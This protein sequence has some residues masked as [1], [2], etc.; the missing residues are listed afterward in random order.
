M[1]SLKY[2]L[3]CLIV[4][5][6]AL[7]VGG[8][9]EPMLT[10]RRKVV[11]PA[12][13][14]L[15]QDLATRFPILVL[16]GFRGPLVMALW[17]QA[18]EL[19]NQRKWHEVT[20]LHNLIA[21]LQ[22]HFGS[23]YVFNAW[24][25]AYNMSAQWQSLEK[26]YEWV[27]KGLDYA[28]L[29]LRYV[30][31]NPDLVHQLQFIYDHKLGRSHEK[32]F[33]RRRFREDSL[34]FPV[35]DREKYPDAALPFDY[36]PDGPVP[37]DYQEITDPETFPFGQSPFY[38]SFKYANRLRRL[39]PTTQ[40]GRMVVKFRTPMALRAWANNEL[41]EG[42]MTA[43]RAYG[44]LPED[45][46]TPEA[47]P[48]KSAR[49]VPADLDETDDVETSLLLPGVKI[50][51]KEHPVE[52]PEDKR[53][54]LIEQAKHH[55]ALAADLYE[56]A[57][58]IFDEYITE[59]PRKRFVHRK[60][61][62]RSRIRRYE[63]LARREL[64]MGLVPLIGTT[65]RPGPEEIRHFSRAVAQFKRAAKQ[66]DTFARDRWPFRYDSNGK[67]IK[68]LDRDDVYTQINEIRRRIYDMASLLDNPN[69]RPTITMLAGPI[70]NVTEEY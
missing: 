20:T 31:D 64:L 50:D 5:V 65:R 68:E 19:K 52:S 48:E 44:V 58:K 26:K 1:S 62:T 60:H 67:L 35:I 29:G 22:P 49:A 63:A 21:H 39:P 30:P 9:M 7:V 45:E 17:M 4:A 10:A 32:K 6:I 55:F 16:G 36:E 43:Y 41:Y 61:Q 46:V 34:K 59:H 14:T 70:D 40:M 47:K 3:V 66:W 13:V 69:T 38:Y 23:V 33:Y 11:V 54:R 27:K 15:S 51:K 37:F 2:K 28:K 18:E 8:L 42:I 53:A 57:E 56:R 24:N 25:Q 12:K